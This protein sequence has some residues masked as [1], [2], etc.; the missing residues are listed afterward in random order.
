MLKV[1]TDGSSRG[2]PGVG[3]ASFV[4]RRDDITLSK[5]SDYVGRVTSNEAEYLAV[6]TAL[7]EIQKLPLRSDQ[8]LEECTI[9]TDSALVVGQL[10]GK[11]KVNA[12]HLKTLMRAC[13]NIIESIPYIITIKHI[14]REENS[15][16]N[17][18]AQDA[19]A[20]GMMTGAV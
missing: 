16:A 8:P 6:F 4:I 13:N 12:P 15:E 3:A 1:W 9:Y 2:N 19:S 5:G 17:K 18:L 20:N 11:W 10:T 14:H 7:Q